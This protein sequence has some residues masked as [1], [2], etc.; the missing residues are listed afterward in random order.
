MAMRVEQSRAEL[1][2]QLNEQMELLSIHCASGRL[3]Y[4]VV[5]TAN[6]HR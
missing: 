1:L 6:K 3:A 2:N 5:E 4:E